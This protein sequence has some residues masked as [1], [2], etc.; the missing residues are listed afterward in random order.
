[1]QLKI[2][3][4]Y[5]YIDLC[6]EEKTC[7]TCPFTDPPE[8]TL[9]TGLDDSICS[10]VSFREDFEYAN[11]QMEFYHWGSL[12]RGT[13]SLKHLLIY[14]PNRRSLIYNNQERIRTGG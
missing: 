12:Y 14:K 1:M 4:V 5:N 6:M 8:Y 3:V 9:L 7:P 10:R 13:T 11:D 2:E